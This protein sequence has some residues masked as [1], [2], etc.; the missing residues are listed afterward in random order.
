MARSAVSV[1]E[2]SSWAEAGSRGEPVPLHL[3]PRTRSSTAV[4]GLWEAWSQAAR[5]GLAGQREAVVGAA[6]REPPERRSWPAFA[7]SRAGRAAPELWD[8]AGPSQRPAARPAGERAGAGAAA[9]TGVRARIP[10]KRQATIRRPPGPAAACRPPSPTRPGPGFPPI[11]FLRHQPTLESAGATGRAPA[12]A[13]PPAC[14]LRQARLPPLR[15]AWPAS[16]F[17][18]K[19]AGAGDPKR[20]GPPDAGLGVCFAWR[21]ARRVP[22]PP[23]SRR[24]A[25]SGRHPARPRQD[26]A[27]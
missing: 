17:R 27:P 3:P 10:R 1:D 4:S 23:P 5:R 19:M 25:P 8:Q 21:R 9:A 20:V 2:R 26:R 7:E 16:H 15:G 13:G 24:P 11:P 22:R 12:G 14:R 6:A 18:P